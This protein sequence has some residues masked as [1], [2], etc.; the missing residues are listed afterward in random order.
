MWDIV[1]ASQQRHRSV[2]ATAS[3]HFLLQAFSSV[4]VP[5]KNSSVETTVAE[6]G[7][8]PV[9]G[10][11]G[12][13]LGGNGP[14]Q[15][16]SSYA[17]ILTLAGCKSSHSGF[18]DGLAL[19]IIRCLDYCIVGSSTVLPRFAERILQTTDR[20]SPTAITISYRQPVGSVHIPLSSQAALI[21]ATDSTDCCPRRG[22][23]IWQWCG[24]SVC[25]GLRLVWNLQQ[26]LQTC[27]LISN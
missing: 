12:H 1:W 20:Q 11:W 26:S 25:H 19:S 8:N 10:L 2:S 6:G 5:C 9:A 15:P 7:R 14:S 4:P 24:F 21:K 22:C 17:S 18:L 16:T 23:Y 13:T 3:H 27:L